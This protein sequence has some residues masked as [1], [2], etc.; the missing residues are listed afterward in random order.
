MHILPTAATVPSRW[1]VSDDDLFRDY[2]RPFVID[3]GEATHLAGGEL[4]TFKGVQFKVVAATPDDGL[5]DENSEF[6]FSGEPVPD[7]AR[8]HL[9]PVYESLP[10]RDKDMTSDQRFSRYLEPAFVGRMML[11]EQGL[12]LRLDGTEWVVMGADPERGLAT[13][14]T[15]V[16][17]AGEPYTYEQLRREQQQRDEQMAREMQQQESRLAL[18]LVRIQGGSAQVQE[19]RQRLEVVMR[20]LPEGHPLRAMLQGMLVEL[21]RGRADPNLL[22]LQQLLRV[23][24]Q[25][26]AGAPPRASQEEIRQ[27]PEV[28]Y[29]RPA[30]PELKA[31]EGETAEAL[32]RRQTQADVDYESDQTCRICLCEYEDGDATRFLPCMHRYHVACIDVWLRTNNTCPI[33]KHPIN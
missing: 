11:L 14:R 8:A 12:R 31:A 32:S 26:A 27:L 33:C 17:C 21:Q 16:H 25:G 4:F 10:N 13:L 9:L 19:L 28:S 30:R 24:Q 29:R 15:V 23:H 2:V 3:E 1:N 18:P 5:L 22:H 6:F 7:L 20:D